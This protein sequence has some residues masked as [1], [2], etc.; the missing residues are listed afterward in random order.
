MWCEMTKKYIKLSSEI[1]LF[2]W[3]V[4]GNCDDKLFIVPLPMKTMITLTYGVFYK[5]KEKFYVI[6][7]IPHQHLRG[8]DALGY[9]TKDELFSEIRNLAAKDRII[10]NVDPKTNDRDLGSF[11]NTL[12]RM[13]MKN[14]ERVIKGQ[15]VLFQ[16]EEMSSN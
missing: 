11:T 9:S 13:N 1:W 6:N 5:G 14:L 3:K 10:I 12:R 8:P 15:E 7:P 16:K 4:L 2:G